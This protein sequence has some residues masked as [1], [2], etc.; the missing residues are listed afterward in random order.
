MGKTFFVSDTH[1]HHQNIIKYSHRP[2]VSVEEMNESLVDNWNK[3]V[4]KGDDVYHL[5][6]VSFG[7]YEKTAAILKRLNGNIHIIWGNHDKTLQANIPALIADT[8][9]KTVQHYRE[10]KINGQMIVLFHFGQRVWNRAHHGAIHLYGHSHGSLPPHGKSVD[11]GVDCKEI[12]PDYR[13]IE[14]TEV[15]EYMKTRTFEAVDHH[16]GDSD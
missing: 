2:F 16:D 3:I 4:K 14:V 7:N 9:V 11:V 8:P 10:I 6:D 1:W 5:G 15:L 12:T 13:P